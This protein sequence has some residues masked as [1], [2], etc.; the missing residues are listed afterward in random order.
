MRKYRE[1]TDEDVIKNAA[2][3]T[4]LSQLLESLNLKKAGGN[5]ANMKKIIQRLGVDTSHWTGKAWN[6]G[7]RLK[8]WSDYTRVS[9]IKKHLIEER[10]KVCE[11]CKTFLWLGKEIKLEVH[12][13][14]GDRTNNSHDNLQLMCPNCHSMTDNW[15]VPHHSHVD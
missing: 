13:V 11:S 12:H 9:K 5:F 7:Q 3:V 10:G 1:Y 6:K 4:S 8:D 2:E 15:R 14:D